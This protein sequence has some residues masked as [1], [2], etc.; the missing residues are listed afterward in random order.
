MALRARDVRVRPLEW[1]RRHRLVVVIEVERRLLRLPQARRVATIALLVAGTQLTVLVVLRVARPAGLL[2]IDV[3]AQA[4]GFV[5]RGV[6]LRAVGLRV[7]SIERK[8]RELVIEALRTVDRG[9]SHEVE[10]ATAVLLMTQL[11]RTSLDL[12]RDVEAFVVI[13][14]LLEIGVLVTTE[15]LVR[16]DRL[17][18][19][20]AR[21]AVVLR[22]E[23]RVTL[24]ELAR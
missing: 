12:R 7:F 6:A 19:L 2:G 13:D 8:P 24:G 20:V 17:V 18:G 1:H 11:A 10:V 5:G 15:A 16:A 14:L 21:R 23:R 9:P 3:D 22:V 4:L